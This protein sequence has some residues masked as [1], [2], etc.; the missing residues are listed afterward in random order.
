MDKGRMLSQSDIITLNQTGMN[1]DSKK[2]YA[3]YGLFDDQLNNAAEPGPF[4]IAGAAM[5]QIADTFVGK[6][7]LWNPDLNHHFRANESKDAKIESEAIIDKQ[8]KLAIGEMVAPIVNENTKNAYGVFE[9][10]PEYIDAVESKKV[11]DYTSVLMLVEDEG[12]DGIN[13]AQGLHVQFVKDPG[14]HRKL[15]KLHGTCIGGIEKCMS[16]LRILGAA[17]KLRE[18]QK[19][20]SNRI[21]DNSSTMDATPAEERISAIEKDVTGIKTSISEISDSMK[22]I[23]GATGS[24]Q[25]GVVVTDVK[26]NVPPGSESK[27]DPVV[28]KLE[29]ELKDMKAKLEQKDKESQE[30]LIKFQEAQKTKIIDN[31][32]SLEQK[33]HDI[34]SKEA[35]DRPKFYADADLKGLELIEKT[36]AKRN[37]KIVGATGFGGQELIILDGGST[38][39]RSILS[40]H[41][42]VSKL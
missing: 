25:T 31:I 29:Q 3:L 1:L 21:S 26:T 32:V 7:L 34:S 13:K 4:K 35:A 24:S 36:L 9:I 5:K 39:K 22:K 37:E 11:P 42:Q 6:P 40:I 2:Y 33:L 8:R 38:Q 15:A 19:S 17:G 27:P 12:K 14:Y 18:Y 10:W 23:V 41:N 30:Q 20:F 28:S 16:D